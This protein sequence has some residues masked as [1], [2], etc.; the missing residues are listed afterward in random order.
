MTTGNV[1]YLVMTIG[2]FGVFALMLAYQ[3]WKQSQLG[4]DMIGT[5][6]KRPAP[7]RPISARYQDARD[8][9]AA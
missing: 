4:S 1:L 3:S 8:A 9:H 2:M 7:Q 6:T 5:S